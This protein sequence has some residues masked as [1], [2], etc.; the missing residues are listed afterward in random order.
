[1]IY[2]L[3]LFAVLAMCVIEIVRLALAHLG[4]GLLPLTLTALVVAA[5][6]H[7]TYG[8][9]GIIGGSPWL[10]GGLFFGLAVVNSVKLAGE[11]KEGF[12]TRKGT[13]YPMSDQVTDVGV[14]VGLYV[15]LGILET[16][17]H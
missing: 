12:G 1:M 6:V 15:I 7:Y 2:G 5:L 13:K 4:V 3:L 17:L 14:M 11:L 16:V 8:L 10:N 9:G